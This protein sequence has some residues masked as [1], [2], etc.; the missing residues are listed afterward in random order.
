MKAIEKLL[1]K[2]VIIRADRAGVFYGTLAEIEPLGDKYQVELT[3]C[4]RIWYWSGAASITQLACEGV[5]NPSACKF[6]MTQKSIVVNGV[7]EVHGCTEESINS[8]EAVA[9]W[10]R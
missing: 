3:D 5:K 4:R 8:I 2:R 1:N 7:I 9:V 10:K 6:T